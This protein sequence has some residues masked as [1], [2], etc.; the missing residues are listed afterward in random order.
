MMLPGPASLCNVS[1]FEPSSPAVAV[2]ELMLLTQPRLVVVDKRL[3]RDKH[4]SVY[5]ASLQILL[6]SAFGTGA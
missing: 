6:S 4:S 2:Q 3:R 1:M 5:Y